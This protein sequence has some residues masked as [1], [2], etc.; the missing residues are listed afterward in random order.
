MC[1]YRLLTLM[2]EMARGGGTAHSGAAM[3]PVGCAGEA[4][5]N[6]EEGDALHLKELVICVEL[7]YETCNRLG[8][9]LWVRM[10]GQAPWRGIPVGDEEPATRVRK[11]NKRYLSNP[12][13]TPG[14]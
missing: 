3:V 10:R 1:H 2:E 7:L 14:T 8:E 13:K 6:D 11:W 5:W 4:G 9:P 12:G